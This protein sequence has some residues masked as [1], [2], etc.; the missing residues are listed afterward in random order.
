MKIICLEEHTPDLNVDDMT[1][2]LL[3]GEGG[4]ELEKQ[5]HSV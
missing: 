1:K 4:T 2:Y 5:T 3:S